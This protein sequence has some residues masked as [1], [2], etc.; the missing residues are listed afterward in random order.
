M[1]CIFVKPI[2]MWYD[3]FMNCG[4]III[5]MSGG[6]DSAVTAL[7]LK[8]QGYNVTGV[9]M[10]AHEYGEEEAAAATAAYLGIPHMIVDCREAFTDKVIS[11][12]VSEYTHGRTPNPCTICNRLIKWD[13]LLRAA[14]E[15]G[16]E[17]IAT[18]HY[19][20]IVRLDSGRYALGQVTAGGKDQTYALY[21]LTQ[22][23]LARTVMPLGMYDKDTVRRT[24]AE[25]G[26]SEAEKP[27]SQEVCFIP[28][29][30]HAAFIERYTGQTLTPGHFVD[31]TGRVLGVH[32]GI[33]RY[34]VGQRK[35]LGIAAGEPIYVT[36]IDPQTGDVVL[37]PD[38]SNMKTE[39]TASGL[40]CMGIAD[41]EE[42][43]DGRLCT[44]KIRY[45]H[46]GTACLVYKT[47][48]D[49]IR[50]VF[51]DPVRA[52][53]PGQAAVIYDLEGHVLGGGQI[54]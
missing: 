10:K 14:D 3:S 45:N 50:V 11:Y 36:R 38:S 12:F 27:D 1:F 18:G 16:A 43:S 17:R 54:E 25:A 28:D 34:T 8:R 15:L 30:D 4:K 33:E 52:V 23:M 35:G 51:E 49:R 22:E 9:T 29:H 26:L 48:E 6:V 41:F 21:N 47:G 7:L 2:G 40:N 5:G 37:G 44:A 19:A 20:R 42:I 39:L 31:E 13:V 24:A 53:T 32:K 46:K